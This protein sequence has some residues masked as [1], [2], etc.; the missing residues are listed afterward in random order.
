[1]KAVLILIIITI[2]VFLSGETFEKG[3]LIEN[4]VCRADASEQYVLYLP[5]AYSEKEKW[6]VL[7]VFKPGGSDATGLNLF[8]PAAGKYGYILISPVNIQNGPGGVIAKAMST[9]WTDISTRF[10]VDKQRIYATGFSGGSRMSSFL[11]LIILNPVRGIIGC[12]AG[13]S[14]D[15]KPGQV[16]SIHYFGIVGF[17]DFNYREM[18]ELE[19][20]LERQGNAHRFIYYDAK[21]RWPPEPICTRAVEWMELMAVKEGLVPKE[22]RQELIDAVFEKERKLAQERE[23]AGEIYFAAADYAAIARVF[24][25][26]KP[27]DELN[28]R[29]D[30]LK[31]SK[32]FKKFHKEENRRLQDEREYNG[33]FFGVLQYIEQSD[34][35]MLPINN[36]LE[37]TGIPRLVSIL[38]KKKNEYNAA[39]AERVL[40]NMT[41]ISRRRGVNYLTTGDLNRAALL[42]K[43]GAASGKETFLYSNILYNLAC[44]LAKQGKKKQAL[45]RLKESVENG[46]N[47]LN[48][49]KTDKDLDT[50][51]DSPEFKKLIEQLGTQ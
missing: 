40:Y 30:T 42:L 17:S 29:A 26:L 19:Q 13:L 5:P 20:I 28:R 34:P 1:M 44:A 11:H 8:K 48:I 9:V 47:N 12:G 37:N 6:P 18:V 4:V 46:F 51:R 16:K 21:H 15:I 50:L 10:S 7:F 23:T 32:A 35:N 41:D 33:K 39:M 25:G 38:K 2:P 45:E 3:K 22:N 24:D 49:L 31:K 27:V 36:I 43:I 14:T